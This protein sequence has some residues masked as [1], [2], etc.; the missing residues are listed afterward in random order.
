MDDLMS[1]SNVRFQISDFHQ[2]PHFPVPSR[3]QL[4]VSL[5][6]RLII[7][8]DLGFRTRYFLEMYLIHS[9]CT[10]H[11][12]IDVFNLFSSRLESGLTLI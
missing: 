5:I 7:A 6:T 8:P 9:D 10:V 12:T 3:R 4:W 1:S 11:S 2:N